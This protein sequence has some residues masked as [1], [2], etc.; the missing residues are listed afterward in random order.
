MI[1]THFH[2]NN[3]IAWWKSALTAI[4]CPL[5]FCPLKEREYPQSRPEDTDYL[6]GFLSERKEWQRNVLEWT[7]MVL[8]LLF[9]ARLYSSSCPSSISLPG[10][11]HITPTAWLHSDDCDPALIDAPPLSLTQD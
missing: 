5:L 7:D 11:S 8:Q 10:A 6:T 4:S 9:K 3:L 1:N 2:Y